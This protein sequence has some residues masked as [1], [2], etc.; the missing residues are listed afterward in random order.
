MTLAQPATIHSSIGPGWAEVIGHTWAAHVLHNAIRHGHVGHAYLLTGPEQVGK[1]MLARIF[2]QALNCAADDVSARPCG[3][4]RACRLIAQDRHPD[5]ILMTPEVSGRGKPSYKIETIRQLQQALQLAPYEG[6]YKV[7][8]LRRFDTAN[9]N[10]ANAFLKTLEEPPERV[11]LLLTA[12]EAEAL[13]ETVRSRCRIL[14]LRPL[15]T[16]LIEQLLRERRQLPP[17]RAALLAHLAQG[18]PGWAIAAAQE[19]G[20]LATRQAHLNALRQALQ[21]KRVARFQLAAQLGE[22]AETL[23]VLLETWLS[24]WRDVLLLA[25][26]AAA[27][28]IT[29]VDLAQELT[30]L[31][32]RWTPDG[33]RAH[34]HNTQTALW[35]LDHNA[36]TL[37]VLENLFLRYP[38]SS[39]A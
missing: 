4:C 28:A 16:D 9:P 30:D 6:R 26:G 33:V 2:A 39:E 20:R 19:P 3:V 29:N 10:A 32:H 5:V 27:A 15:P 1:T 37:L 7:A 18:R 34:L 11:I 13:L 38:S 36:N 12:L 22:Q 17:E 23:P 21:G 35:Q 8:I 31:A 25:N 24:W 14:A